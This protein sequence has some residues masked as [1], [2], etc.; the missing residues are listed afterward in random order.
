MILITGATGNIGSA[1]VTQLQAQQVPFR[2]LAHTPASYERLRAQQVDAVLLTEP[3]GAEVETAFAGVDRVFLLTPSS[4]DQAEIERGF[5]DAAQHAGVQHI[6]K[7]SVLGADAPDV[8][9]V[10]AHREG[11]HYI[12]QSGIDYTFL[13]P[14]AF[15]QNVGTADAA[16]IKQQSAIFN[17]AGNGR[18][19]FIDSRD[20]AAVAAAVLTNTGHSG[21]T[22][23]LTG[24]RA[25]SYSEV[26]QQLTTL[27]DRPIRYVPLDDA[28]FYDALV[29]AGLPSWYAEGL[30][31]LYRFYRAGNGTIVTDAVERT[32]GRAARTF[33]TYLADHR[34]LFA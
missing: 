18:I 10:Q 4:G 22:Y 6:V 12:R 33:A 8:S 5:V 23:E 7:L 9:L 26:A 28:A 17:A 14:N 25:L 27:L 24:P 2:A 34:A 32:T 11:E 31:D 16:M 19:S 30:G 3:Q 13:R 20:I 29:S 21:Q 15:M 1:L